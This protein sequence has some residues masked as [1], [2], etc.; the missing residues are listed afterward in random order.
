[1]HKVGEI[2]LEFNSEDIIRAEPN[3]TW[4][5]TRVTQI[6]RKVWR[7]VLKSNYLEKLENTSSF[8]SLHPSHYSTYHLDWEEV[9]ASS[10]IFTSST[11]MYP[12]SFSWKSIKISPTRGW[13]IEPDAR[14]N[15]QSRT[16]NY[17]KAKSWLKRIQ[18]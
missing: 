1:M 9:M 8:M 5:C 2:Y 6:Q 15:Y 11:Y 10:C 12:C 7:S 14:P 4:E 17:M 18:I 13:S 3:R 16:K